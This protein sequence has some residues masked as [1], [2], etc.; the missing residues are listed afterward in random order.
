M[1][2]SRLIPRV[3]PPPQEGGGRNERPSTGLAWRQSPGWWRGRGAPPL[4]PP[5]PACYA[6]SGGGEGRG[7]AALKKIK[8]PLPPPLP[9]LHSFILIFSPAL[10]YHNLDYENN[11]C[12]KG[13]GDLEK[14]CLFLRHALVERSSTNVKKNNKSPPF[15]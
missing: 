11:P 3:P 15:S 4:Y 10:P 1:P 9:P 8:W 2:A 12:L 5:L 14:T 13:K 7:E 6:G